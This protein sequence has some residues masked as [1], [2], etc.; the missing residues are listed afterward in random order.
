MT[1]MVVAVMTISLWQALLASERE[2]A[3]GRNALRGV[4]GTEVEAEDPGHVVQEAAVDQGR[5]ERNGIPITFRKFLGGG[6]AVEPE[7]LVE[8]K[9]GV[10][11]LDGRRGEGLLPVPGAAG[12]AVHEEEGDGRNRD[13]HRDDP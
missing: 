7:R 4:R 12:R 10:E 1:G 6:I 3:E 13:D 2:A 9:L 8:P 5:G 11:R